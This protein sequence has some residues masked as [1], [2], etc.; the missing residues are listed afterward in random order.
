MPREIGYLYVSKTFRLK[1][2]NFGF[3]VLSLGK[4]DTCDKIERKKNSNN[5]QFNIFSMIIK[6]KI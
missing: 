1:I 2:Y 5:G 3:F 6:P 4:K